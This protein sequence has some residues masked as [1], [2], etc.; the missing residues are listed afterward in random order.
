MVVLLVDRVAQASVALQPE[1]DE[2]EHGECADV[3]AGPEADA[4]DR[5]IDLIQEHGKWVDA[6]PLQAGG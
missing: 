3:P 6:E 5:L 2:A 1:H 4:V